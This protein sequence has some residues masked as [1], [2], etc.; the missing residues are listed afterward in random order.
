MSR[1]T[2]RMISR[3]VINN[4]DLLP[5]VIRSVDIPQ[6][7][8]FVTHFCGAEIQVII[9]NYLPSELLLVMDNAGNIGI[10]N[11]TKEEE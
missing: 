9:N 11:A 10:L 5:K 6:P 3:I 1:L 4:L 7:K 8:K 2:N